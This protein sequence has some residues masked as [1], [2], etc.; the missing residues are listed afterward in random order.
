[1]SDRFIRASTAAV[2]VGI[3]GIAAYISYQHALDVAT[4]HGEAGAT[5]RLVPLTIDGLVYVASM[6]LLDSAR[7]R[8]PAPFLARLALALGI[9]ATVAVNVL[10][11]VAH[12]VVGALIGAWPAVCLVLVVE[13]LMG[14]VRRGR[15]DE[16]PRI[17]GTPDETAAQD[18]FPEIAEPLD[19]P[20]G[21]AMWAEIEPE[22]VATAL[23]EVPDDGRIG[24]GDSPSPNETPA[25]LAP[26]LA[27]ARDRFAETLASGGLPSVRALRR[28]LHIGHPRAVRVRAALKAESAPVTV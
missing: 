13:M 22:P 14:M 10:H 17:V 25:D 4:A 28:E 23:P 18:D 21:Y 15:T 2:V 27:T 9:G 6:V 3:G 8:V 16:G 7:R 19:V 26:V 24:H 12:G 5:G 1:M 20:D 11:G